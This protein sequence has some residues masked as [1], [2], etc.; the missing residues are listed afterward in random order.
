LKVLSEQ[1]FNCIVSFTYVC[2][3][4]IVELYRG[5]YGSPFAWKVVLPKLFC[6][7][8][9]LTGLAVCD[10]GNKKETSKVKIGQFQY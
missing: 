9:G 6:C 10:I 7:S 4:K 3:T 5:P 1:L 8:T 2:R